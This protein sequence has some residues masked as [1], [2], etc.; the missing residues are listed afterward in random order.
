M[1]SSSIFL[2]ITFK[3][4]QKRLIIILLQKSDSPIKLTSHPRLEPSQQ[5]R[6]IFSPDPGP[7][8]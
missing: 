4:A 2:G 7:M 1:S 6:A 5:R 8:V 3:T